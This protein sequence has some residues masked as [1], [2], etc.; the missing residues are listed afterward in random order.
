MGKKI[1]VLGS[2]VVDLMGRA[3]HLPVP[4]ETVKGNFF[5]MGPGGKGSNQA[6]ASH[7]AG[8]DVALITKVGNDAFASVAIDFYQSEG[9]DT[10]FVFT[11]AEFGTGAALILVDEHDS[12]NMILV[13]PGA[14]AHLSVKE[15]QS[16][17]E[18]L[19]HS[20]VL[21]AQLET[22][23][24]IL[25]LAVSMVHGHGGV[26]ILNPA[27]AQVVDAGL[28]GLFDI[29]TPN[30][31]EASALT[32]IS[33][34]DKFSADKAAEAFMGMGVKHVVI[35]MGGRGAFVKMQSG[36]SHLFPAFPADVVDTTGAGDAFNGGLATALAEGFDLLRA[37]EFASAT[38]ALSVTKVGTA[39]AMPYRREID[40]CLVSL[41]L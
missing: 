16:A 39:P 20:S 29:V 9:M 11:D 17:R 19:E 26:A 40:A 3:E 10:R 22:N 2:F 31:V 5:R 33:V 41:G 1:T 7:R 12:Q 27:P 30:E 6:V 32:G 28:I 14:C 36:K 15:I 23:L 25:P 21:L 8:G 24:D 13:Y 34:V 38:A 18:V 37:V 35:T 4:A